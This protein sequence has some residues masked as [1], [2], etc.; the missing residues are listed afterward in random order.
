MAVATHT[1]LNFVEAVADNIGAREPG[2]LTAAAAGSVT[3]ANY[4]FKTQRTNASAKT[5]EGDEIY[6]TSGT[7]AVL[8]PQ[9]IAV[10]APS[11]GVFTP[12]ITYTTAPSSTA[13][14]DIFT[15]GVR[16]LWIQNAINMALRKIR[17]WSL[18]PITLVADGNMESSGTTSW[19]AT[20]A[21]LT[22]VTNSNVPRGARALRVANSSA[23][24]QAQSGTLQSAPLTPS[25]SDYGGGGR[26]YYCHAWCRADVGTGVLVAYD[27]TNSATIESQNWT[28]EKWGVIDFT[29][30]VPATCEEFAIVLRGTESTADIYWTNVICHR[31]GSTE[32]ALPDWVTHSEFIR[33][34][35][36]GR[37]NLGLPD[38]LKLDEIHATSDADMANAN[39]LFQLNIHSPM[40]S[41]PYWYLGSRPFDALSLDADTTTA[42]REWLE[43]AGTMELCKYLHGRF[44]KNEEWEQAYKEWL[45]RK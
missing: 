19:T 17:Y 4:P 18:Y 36:M 14:F 29:F 11:T 37:Y 26:D 33:K 20:T 1:F 24:G 31:L 27:V 23:N 21:T 44:R 35:F 38:E 6:T 8:N 22:K 9:Q 25:D 7:A 39:S 45:D 2:T 12:G 30:T 32:V 10:Y 3:A 41:H 16:L 40:T 42:D 5:Y 15:K 28:N 43:A 34:V 13:T